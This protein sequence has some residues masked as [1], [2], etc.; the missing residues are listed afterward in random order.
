M[1]AL[2]ESNNALIEGLYAGH[3]KER[4]IADQ[5]AS[6]LSKDLKIDE[7]RKQLSKNCKIDE[8]REEMDHLLVDQRKVIA[9]LSKEIEHV[10]RNTFTDSFTDFELSLSS[11]NDTL[12]SKNEMID[13]QKKEIASLDMA[14]IQLMEECDVRILQLKEV[15]E[16]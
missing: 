6:F 1:A 3:C 13:K 12:T 9:S 14:Y 8:Y 2:E 16:V 4:I 10:R 11:M 7:Q 5:C 15:F